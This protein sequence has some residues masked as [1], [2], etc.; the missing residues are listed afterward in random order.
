MHECVTEGP[1]QAWQ[2]AGLFSG[3]R[4]SPSGTV[5]QAQLSRGQRGAGEL[6]ESVSV[7]RRW[8]S[9]ITGKLLI[10]AYPQQQASDKPVQARG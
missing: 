6:P 9:A 4:M 2:P 3:L 8:K 5:H 1:T 7:A 10:S